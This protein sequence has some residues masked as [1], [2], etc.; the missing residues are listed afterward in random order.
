[1]VYVGTPGPDILDLR[2]W[3]H[4]VDF[5]IASEKDPVYLRELKG[6]A[7]KFGWDRRY[8][9]TTMAVGSLISQQTEEAE[10]LFEQA[11]D[12][13]TIV[14]YDV[15]AHPVRANLER[16]DRNVG[17]WAEIS[18]F[19]KASQDEAPEIVL[20][21]TANVRGKGTYCDSAI[22]SIVEE[23]R[24]YG[25]TISQEDS[26]RFLTCS[27]AKKTQICIPY[28]LTRN[29]A[30][31]SGFRLEVLDSIAYPGTGG[32]AM[33]HLALRFRSNP[34]D[35]EMPEIPLLHLLNFGHR[36][37][38]ESDGRFVGRIEVTP[39]IGPAR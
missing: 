14:N 31:A 29:G 16:F 6:N 19:L 34:V 24:K 1:V 33:F 35:S 37:V 13:P 8:V 32:K 5:A 15:Y 38:G 26:D 12:W 9:S 20:L 11:P 17:I 3:Q 27:M 7:R 4:S 23:T 10:Q 39:A 22:R 28:W 21:L 30:T 36:V 25:I 2:E 18:S